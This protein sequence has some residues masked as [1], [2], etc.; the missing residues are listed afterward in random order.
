MK[1]R[2]MYQLSGGSALALA[3]AL[4]SA[5]GASASDGHNY[6]KD[7]DHGRTEQRDWDNKKA[8]WNK[9][10]GWRWDAKQHRMVAYK[11][12]ERNCDPKMTYAK[13][14]KH[15]SWSKDRNCDD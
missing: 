9:H 7:C 14:E 4:V 5:G 3:F 11:Y 12:D 6:N 8:D 1:R 15:D 13:Y 2:L 10:H